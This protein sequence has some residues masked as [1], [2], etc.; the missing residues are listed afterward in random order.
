M[1]AKREITLFEYDCLVSEDV[2]QGNST[3]AHIQAISGS[4]YQYLKQ[5]CLSSENESNLLQLRRRSGMEVLQVQNY[6][7]VIFTPDKTQIE[8]LPK[9]GKGFIGDCSERND[10][11]AHVKARQSLLIMLRALKGFSHIQTSNANI[12]HQR[13]PLLEV[14]ISQFLQSVS[15]LIKRGLRSDYVRREDNLA[16]LKGKLNIGKQVQHSFVNKHKFYCE[17]DEFLIDRPVNRLIHSALRKVKSYTRSAANQKMLQDLEFAFHEV[18]VSRN[19]KADF[20]KVRL[21]RGMSYYQTPLDWCRLILEGFSPQTMRG[22]AHAASLLFPMEKVFEDYVAKMLMQDL[23][24]DE[25]NLT[26]HTQATGEYLASYNGVN[27]FSLRPDILIKRYGVNYMVLDTKWK[28][29][30]TKVTNSNI[31]QSD[32]YQLYAYAKKY[33]S[34]EGCG[35]DVVLIYPAQDN[36]EHPLKYPFDLGD[37]H[38]LWI[39]PFDIEKGE[40]GLL[41]PQTISSNF[42]F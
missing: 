21:D 2:V 8:V 36:F 41:L 31:S 35:Q 5:L 27:K 42:S 13:M 28:L 12:E 40:C 23:S 38:R 33:L 4:A 30:D 16:F 25:R 24:R 9:I 17:F 22:D 15:R 29:L 26:V 14:F 39:L 34:A 1:K 10:D 7:G 18:P 19:Y 20:S 11:D 3:T 32:V 6:A 37:G